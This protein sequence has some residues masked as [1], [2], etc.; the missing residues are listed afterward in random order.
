MPRNIEDIIVPERKRSIRDIPI[1]LSRRRNNDHNVETRPS[2]LSVHR[3]SPHRK[4]L[5]VAIGVAGL[6]LFFAALSL[7]SG[8][9]LSYVP[10][11]VQLTFTNDAFNAKKTGET[12][13]LFSIIKFAKDKG[14]EISA[15]GEE[16]VSRKASGSIIVYN[17]SAKAQKLRATTRF[18]TPEGKTYQIT[19]GIV[20]PAKKVVGGVDKPGM[21]EVVV[22]SEF[23]GAE[24][25]IGLSDFT[26]PGL[27]GSSL[28]SAIYARSK[29]EMSGGFV[30]I[31]K[32]V[33][34]DEAT[35]AQTA[36]EA[37]LKEELVSEA[38]AQVPEDFVLVSS[39]STMAFED[40]PQTEST[41]EN[42][43][44]INRRGHLQGV[45]FK[46]S[47]LSTY[48]ALEKTK[49]TPGELVDLADN[50]ALT[51]SFSDTPR[52]D[53]TSLDEIKFNVQGETTAVWRID[54]V[55]LKADLAG[56]SK[57]DLYS[58]LNNYPNVVSATAT[59]R[60]FWKNSFPS[61]GAK[62]MVKKLP[63]N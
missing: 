11:S 29:T 3:D 23:P 52:A 17:N 46:R 50:G 5:W 2:E 42:H 25:N 58:V 21:L 43:A 20:L 60:P 12:G 40:L 7:F 53:L 63:V 34:Q 45:M 28:S 13:L 44:T 22:Y 32:V 54:E 9:T 56:K 57:K 19:D 24:H 27:K 55:A 10:K 26:L 14:Q 33:D 31:E 36:L 1:P 49:I 39:L 6:I 8:A 18:A 61:D 62:I 51:F 37:A 16:K 35:R 59:I 47:D 15:S 4:G 41:S 38:Q 30:G 48:L